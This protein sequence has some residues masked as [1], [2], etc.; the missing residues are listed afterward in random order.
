[1]LR[2]TLSLILATSLLGAPMALPATD[3]FDRND[4]TL[5]SAWTASIGLLTTWTLCSAAVCAPDHYG[6]TSQEIGSDFNVAFNNL[7]TYNANQYSQVAIIKGAN[8]YQGACVRVTAGNGYCVDL[9]S[10]CTFYEWLS[11][12]RS[13]LG[14]CSSHTW[15]DGHTLK[16][17][18]V[19]TVLTVYDNGT[20][21]G[22]VSN[23]D[24]SSGSAGIMA[25]Q[26]VPGKFY[27]WEGGN[28]GGG[29]A[30]FPGAIINAPIRCCR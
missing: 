24:I 7:D 13:V 6:A 5:G 29:G 11:S 8:G 4:S 1:M 3:S 17:D 23:G 12:S 27:D 14:T 26:N 19:G 21:F 28:T 30:T 10:N 9:D 22:T 18:V 25:Y 2:F 16:L 15:T 20:S